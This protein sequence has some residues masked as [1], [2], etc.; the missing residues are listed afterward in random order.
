MLKNT[1]LALGVTCGLLAAAPA[2]ALAARTGV[3]DVNKVYAESKAGKAA[4]AHLAKVQAVLQNG[5]AELEKRMEKAKKEERERELAAGRA[6][7]ERQLQI[8]LAA[9]RAVVNQH[10]LKAV[11]KWRG[12]DGVVLAKAQVLDYGPKLDITARII[13]DMDKE[14]VKFAALPVVSFKDDKKK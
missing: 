8:E 1:L 4:D 3:V 9:A 12:K 14:N 10:M 2:D 5:F 7:L 11:T 6:V 13:K